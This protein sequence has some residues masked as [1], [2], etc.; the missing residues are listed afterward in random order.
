MSRSFLT[1]AC[2]GAQLVATLDAA[3]GAS[4]LLIVSGGNETR[5]GAGN[6]QAR[7]AARLAARGAPVL[8]FD[9]RGVGD[10]SGPNLGFRESAPDIAAALAALRAAQPHL[11]RIAAFGNCDAA[12]ALMLAQG[13]GADALILANPWSHDRDDGAPD[14]AALRHHYRRRLADR[15]ALSR[16]LTGRIALKPLLASLRGTLA[17]AV[18]ESALLADMRQG[19]AGFTGPAHILLAE[20]DRTAQAFLAAWDRR[21]PRLRR[22]A[23]ASHGFVEPAAQ[24]WLE[25]AILQS[26]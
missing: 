5:A 14:P 24:A 15:G 8:R 16:L 17:P 25:E 1:I 4:G 6:G 26:L 12:S 2:E 13:A 11:T 10:S 9:R 3:P 7:L 21:D 18:P 23:G 22:C 19:L 20:R